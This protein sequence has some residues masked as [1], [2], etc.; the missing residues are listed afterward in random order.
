MK[1][2]GTFKSEQ[3]FIVRH[4]LPIGPDSLRRLDPSGKRMLENVARAIGE[5]VNPEL[6]LRF[7]S[8]PLVIAIE[9]M[10]EMAPLI[11]VNGEKRFK[12][13]VETHPSLY[14]GS[15]FEG[16][17]SFCNSP[18]FTIA[19]IVAVANKPFLEDFPRWY[20]KEVLGGKFEGEFGEEYARGIYIDLKSG[21]YEP[22]P[23]K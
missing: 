9:T 23:S 3:L 12:G 19:P 1:M 14:A 10:I 20:V 2:M 13:Y 7:V 11:E 15:G 5:K 16:F 21:K 17:V 4:G 22:L 6:R 8:S 18:P